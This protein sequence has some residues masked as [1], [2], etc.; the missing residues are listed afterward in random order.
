MQ[1]PQRG[2]CAVGTEYRVGDHQR[3][4]L[5]PAGE[6]GVH[7]L[8]VA[9]RTQTG[10]APFPGDIG[11]WYWGGAGG[12]YM[13][14]DPARDLVVVWMMQSPRQR[15]HYRSLLRDMVNAAVTD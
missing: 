2:Q 5:A 9:V 15:L 3:A 8:G 7:G 1:R 4:I 13:W 11:D 14:V 10:V 12:T 6:H